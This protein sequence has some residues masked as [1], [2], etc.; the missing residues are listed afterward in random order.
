MLW[1]STCQGNTWSRRAR[2]GRYGLTGM[3]LDLASALLSS[4]VLV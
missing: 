2:M 4:E 1:R 3:V